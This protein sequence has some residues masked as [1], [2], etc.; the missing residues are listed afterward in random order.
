MRERSQGKS[1]LFGASSQKGKEVK[2]MPV[3]NNREDIIG[4]WVGQYVYHPECFES[5]EETMMV[6]N[7]LRGD[8]LE[9]KIFFCA[10]CRK[11]IK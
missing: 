5:I 1:K 6:D 3:F 4:Y 2:T 9:K 11:E 8:A 7:V 10:K